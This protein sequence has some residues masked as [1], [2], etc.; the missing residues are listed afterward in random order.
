M[1]GHKFSFPNSPILYS[2]VGN[3]KRSSSIQGKTSD[4]LS[5]NCL[6]YRY[7]ELRFC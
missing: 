1:L 7:I 4:Y 5:R 6:Y 3:N 2:V